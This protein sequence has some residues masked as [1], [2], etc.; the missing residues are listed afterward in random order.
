MPWQKYQSGGLQQDGGFSAMGLRLLTFLALLLVEGRV[1]LNKYIPNV[2]YL[3]I[4]MSGLTQR[5]ARDDSLET[6]HSPREVLTRLQTLQ[7]PNSP[8]FVDTASF[9]NSQSH[10]SSF[11]L[12]EC[13]SV[14][15]AGLNS[16]CSPGWP[17]T[18]RN[19][20]SSAS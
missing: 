10:F 8:G 12:T 11:F 13:H 6:K 7:H 4:R 15:Q 3:F 2:F 17:G 18:C 1:L 9:R 14:A 16:L 5:W 19:P 20:P